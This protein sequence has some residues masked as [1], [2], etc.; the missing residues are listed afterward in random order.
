VRQI[1]VWSNKVRLPIEW[2]K[3]RQL[4]VFVPSFDRW[5]LRAETVLGYEVIDL[6]NHMDGMHSRT[7]HVVVLGFG[8]AFY[9]HWNGDGR[10]K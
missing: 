3:R 6:E 7:I 10:Y 4:S 8:F 1:V 5:S 2:D 9:T